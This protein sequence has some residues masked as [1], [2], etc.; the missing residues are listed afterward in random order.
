[1]TGKNYNMYTA[2]ALSFL[3]PS[4]GRLAYGI[5]MIVFVNLIVLLGTLSAAGISRLRMGDTGRVLQLL[6]LVMFSVLFKQLLALY[7]PVIALTLGFSL[8][9]ALMSSFMLGMLRVP[10]C[11]NQ[12]SA[13]ASELKNNFSQTG[14]FSCCA[15]VFYC[16]RDLIAFGSLTLPVPAGVFE[17]CLFPVLRAHPS[18]FRNSIPFAVILL[19]LSVMLA[20]FISRKI[21]FSERKN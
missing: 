6:V 1:M 15:V 13:L 18:F 20:S 17:C 9:L 21:S 14:I 19:A 12:P 2:A 7:S 10:P 16:V 8:Y 3:V 5:V 11:D 4:P